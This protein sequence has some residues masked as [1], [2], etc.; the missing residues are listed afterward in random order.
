MIN[1]ILPKGMIVS[2]WRGA[3]R[4][5]NWWLGELAGLLP[6]KW[7]DR[8][9][10]RIEAS[11]HQGGVD[12]RISGTQNTFAQGRLEASGIGSEPLARAIAQVRGRLPVWVFPPAGTVLSRLVQVPRSVLGRF[13]GLVATESERWTSFPSEEIYLGW[14]LRDNDAKGKAT[15]ALYFI[16]RALVEPTLHALRSRGLEPSLLVLDVSERISVSLLAGGLTRQQRSHRAAFAAVA[17]AAV[18]FLM[19]DWFVAVH[20]LDGLHRQIA[21]ERQQFSR[22]TDIETKIANVLAVSSD[23]AGLTARSRND[24]LAAVSQALPATDWLTEAAIRGA[25]VTMRGYTVQP[26]A[27]IKALEP[28]AKDQTVMLQ[29]E[30]SVDKRFN[31]NRFTVVLQLP[32]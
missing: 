10:A 19:I 12:I 25:A 3:R 6:R 22:Q 8:Q 30:L 26:E 24:F 18:T 29:G 9:K 31:R 7:R 23:G 5:A 27:L 14:R 4:A 2:G 1:P 15:V 21:L 11:M 16:P 20:K 17:L 28:L 32:W 13:D